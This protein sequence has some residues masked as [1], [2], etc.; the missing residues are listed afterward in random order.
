MLL[1]MLHATSSYCDAFMTCWLMQ[2]SWSCL[3]MGKV[4][5]QGNETEPNQNLAVYLKQK[6]NQ[7]G[8]E[9]SL[10][11]PNHLRKSW[12]ITISNQTI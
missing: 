6:P 1:V 10:I 4:R 11:K 2:L 9:L 5:F 3:A 12:H 7:I 8:Y